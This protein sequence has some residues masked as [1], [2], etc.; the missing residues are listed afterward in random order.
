MSA[1]DVILP[2]ATL[3][4]GG[5]GAALLL[6]RRGPR[7]EPP[8]SGARILFPFVGAELSERAL[9]AALRLARAENATVVPAYLVS[10]PLP[11]ELDA[12]F[13]RTCDDA[14]AVFEAVE[15]RAARAG[16]HVDSRIAR[17][18]NVRHALRQLMA[19]VPAQRV[20]VAAAAN[21]RRDGF[22]VDDVAWL[23]RNAPHEVVVLRPD[24]PPGDQRNATT[25]R[26]A[27]TTSTPSAAA[28]PPTPPVDSAA[29]WT[30]DPTDPRQ[31]ARPLR[32]ATP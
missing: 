8:R 6:R 31:T 23:L 2:L 1:L 16:V 13:P 9:Q 3:V 30:A 17:G 14:F 19:E 15:Q 4:L 25:R 22:S 28:S 21:G 29:P 11:L 5:A 24:Q 10:V 26:Y 7:V 18:R 12:P 20:V 27:G 32:N